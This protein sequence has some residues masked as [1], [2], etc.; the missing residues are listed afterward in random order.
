MY[1][2]NLGL[3]YEPASTLDQKA[4]LDLL[5]INADLGRL[6]GL[7]KMWLTSPDKVIESGASILDIRNLLVDIKKNQEELKGRVERL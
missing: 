5:K 2:R 4:I 1:L 6:G 3:G 7:L